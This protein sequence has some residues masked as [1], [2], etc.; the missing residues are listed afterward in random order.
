MASTRSTDSTPWLPLSELESTSQISPFLKTHQFLPVYS[1]STP[2]RPSDAVAGHSHPQRRRRNPDQSLSRRIWRSSTQMRGQ[3]SWSWERF[4]WAWSCFWWDATPKRRRLWAPKGR[5]WRNFGTMWEDMQFTPLLWVPVLFTPFSC[6]FSSSWRTQFLL[7]LFWL[8]LGVGFSL[9]PR[10]SLPWLVSLNF[11]MIM[12]IDHP[13]IFTLSVLAFG[14]SFCKC[15]RYLIIQCVR[16][17]RKVHVR[18]K[19][20]AVESLMFWHFIIT[21]TSCRRML[22]LIDNTLEELLIWNFATSLIHHLTHVKC[23]KRSNWR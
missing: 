23:D 7:F 19:K 6:P 20:K 4:R 2:P 9:S 15:M 22:N 1:Q 16:E 17:F 18:L 10:C 8:F 12:P 5:W 3:G 13:K 11:P 14:I 21:Y